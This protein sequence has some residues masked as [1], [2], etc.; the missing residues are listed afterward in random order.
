MKWIRLHAALLLALIVFGAGWLLRDWLGIGLEAE[1]I[2]ARVDGLGWVA[3]FAFL[4]L[5]VF[6]TFLVIPSSV[7]LLAGGLLFG[8]GQ[9]TL[10]GGLGLFVGAV[11]W[12]ALAR[13]FG[14]EW[15]RARMGIG[16]ERIE[17]HL[18]RVGPLVV[19]LATAH[20]AG[21]TTPVHVAAGIAALPF[22]AFVLATG[23]GSPA[24]AF[25]YSFFGSTLLDPGS[26]EFYVATAFIVGVFALPLLHPAVRRRLFGR[27]GARRGP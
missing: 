22:G 24:R 15:L 1:A 11:L 16:F 7:L 20:P 26:P 2:R 14:R 10:L 8:V 19:G 18:G 12:F 6:R 17:P 3:P 9:A 5:V 4:L 21:P 13:S 25:A 23:L 27:L